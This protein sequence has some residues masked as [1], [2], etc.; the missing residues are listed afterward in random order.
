MPT[1]SGIWNL[2][3]VRDGI[4]GALYA[5]QPLI[6]GITGN[7]GLVQTTLTISG[8]GF[9]LL[10]GT[11]RFTS[12]ATIADVL[13][14]P[15]SD[16]SMTVNVPQAIYDLATGSTVGIKFITSF[17]AQ[18]NTFNKIV[19]QFTVSYLVI[20]GGGAGGGDYRGAGGGAGG[21]RTNYTSDAS[22][23]SPKLSGGGA[24]VESA[25][26]IQTNNTYNLTVGAG[27]TGSV[28]VG[29][30][31]GKGTDGNPSVFS[32]ITSLGGG[33]G[34]GN[35]V[36]GEPKNSDSNGSAGGSGGGGCGTDATDGPTIGGAGTANQGFV[37][38]AGVLTTQLGGGGGGAGQA[39]FA[40]TGSGGTEGDGGYGVFS[41]ITGSAVQ[42]GGGGGGGNYSGA[43]V[44]VGGAGGG[45]AGG[46]GGYYSGVAGTANFGGGGGG[47]SGSDTAN[48]GG[49]GGSG[50]IILKYADTL[51][52]SNPSGGL[53][54]TTTTVGGFKVTTFTAG[55]GN[56]LF[57]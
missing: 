8:V 3:Q 53:T 54:S 47:A 16:V 1:Q 24:A 42:R 29:G 49:N 18:S 50:V 30:L 20:A 6:D 55:T 44:T 52:L 10:Q 15:A 56:I 33:A 9:G 46:S 13:V 26:I 11:V 4:A 23:P 2:K 32:T 17:G 39:G 27:G 43:N 34:G 51:T 35:Y 22:V 21:Y 45:G 41:D 12:G 7:I 28:P 19:T 57:A 31:G 5:Q 14:T 36:G 25:L 40:A 37:G 48:Q 38:G